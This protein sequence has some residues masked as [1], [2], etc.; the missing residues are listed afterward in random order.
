M[1]QAKRKA[2]GQGPRSKPPTG[3]YEYPD[4]SKPKLELFNTDQLEP[5]AT[6][7]L[8]QAECKH[9]RE[10]REDENADL[11][12]YVVK[13]QDPS[14]SRLVAVARMCEEC[15]SQDV[16]AATVAR[17]SYSLLSQQ[18]IINSMLAS[19]KA[20]K[21]EWQN[22]SPRAKALSEQVKSAQ[23]VIAKIKDMASHLV[24]KT[25]GTMSEISAVVTTSKGE[26]KGKFATV[27]L[28]DEN[29][30]PKL[31]NLLNEDGARFV[32]GLLVTTVNN[33]KALVA[34]VDKANKQN[35]KDVVALYECFGASKEVAKAK[36]LAE[37]KR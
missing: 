13:L 1:G 19:E 33:K 29:C 18:T 11:F 32:C 20:G 2:A 8:V 14:D 28:N 36:T 9:V 25:G 17:M 12:G 6:E 7:G 35:S 10:S 31:V 23:T 26:F 34:L 21:V 15:T 30:I 27:G 4:G 37:A 16:V 22:V 24:D 5:E 3:V